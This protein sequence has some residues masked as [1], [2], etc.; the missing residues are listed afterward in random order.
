MLKNTLVTLNWKHWLQ[1]EMQTWT[2]IENHQ[3]F[4]NIEKEKSMKWKKLDEYK[5]WKKQRAWEQYSPT[6]S[7]KFF[8]T[9]HKLRLASDDH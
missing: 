4:E 2:M 5:W 7:K 6:K 1:I 8:G 9:H 3:K